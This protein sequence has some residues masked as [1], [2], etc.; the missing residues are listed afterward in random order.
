M[1][2]TGG[3]L[4]GTGVYGCTF[5]PAPR[6]NTHKNIIRTIDGLPAVGKIALDDTRSELAIG[7]RIMS[8]PSA[9]DY[10]A[11]PN[12]SCKPVMPVDDPDAP[13]CNILSNVNAMTHA[14]ELIMPSAGETLLEW[15]SDLKRLADNYLPI[16]K[17]LLEGMKKY[18]DA[19]F[20]HNDIHQG[21]ILIDKKGVARYIDFGLAYRPVDVREI[22]DANL[23][24]NFRPQY[25]W[26]A[27]EIH[28]WR[29]TLKGV[30]IADGVNQLR[31]LNP[32]YMKLERLFPA[33][34][35]ADKALTAFMLLPIVVKRDFGA[36][37]RAYGKRFDAWRLGLCMWFLWYDLVKWPGLRAH[38]LWKFEK[39]IRHI[40]GRLTNFDIQERWDAEKALTLFV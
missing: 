24:R 10:F 2:Q 19:G 13:K 23:S 35:S 29:M 21:N 34:K 28:A 3:R 20:I 16:F 37:V 8:L 22:E 6:C 38:P 27:P 17:H 7:Q 5:D 30:R 33:H 1:S 40:L 15:S 39:Q 31:E 12:Y 36:V 18:Q 4:L 26:Q 32:E 11:L 9:S 14:T 25:V